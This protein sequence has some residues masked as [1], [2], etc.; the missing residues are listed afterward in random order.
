MTDIL[1]D[2]NYDL[3]LTDGDLVMGE[4]TNQHQALNLLCN[5]GDFKEDPLQCVGIK[6]Y[7]KSE[8]INGLLAETKKQFERDGMEVKSLTIDAAGNMKINAPF[9]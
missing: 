9:K 1:L 3:Q 8:D 6:G 4:S 5:K 7:L 2:E